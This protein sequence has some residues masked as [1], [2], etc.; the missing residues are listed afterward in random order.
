M[1]AGEMPRPEVLPEPGAELRQVLAG[2]SRRPVYQCGG[3]IV[4]KVSRSYW[5]YTIVEELLT[6]RVSTPMNGM[7]SGKL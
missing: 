6:G 1:D 7:L 2:G 5:A 3:R 4:K